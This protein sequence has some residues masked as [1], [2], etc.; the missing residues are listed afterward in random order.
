MEVPTAA[1]AKV[2]MLAAVGLAT[3]AAVSLTTTPTSR[4]P[5][6]ASRPLSASWIATD[7]YPDPSFVSFTA[8]SYVNMLNDPGRTGVFEAA[9]KQRLKGREGEMVVLDIGTGP[10]ALLALF[11]ARAGAKKVYAV[12]VQPAV[13]E[14]AR[15]AVRA[16][17]DVPDGCIE[18]FEGF[19][20]ELE[21]PEP[22]DLLVSEIVGNIAS[23]EGIYATMWDAQQRLVRHPHDPATYIPLVVETLAAPMSY[24]QHHPAL[25][26]EDFDWDA[27]REYAPPPRLSTEATAVTALSAPQRLETIRFDEPLPPPGTVLESVLNFDVCAERMAASTKA[28]EALLLASREA[29][30]GLDDDSACDDAAMLNVV[31]VSA[32]VGSSVSGI[33]LWPR[34][35]MDDDASLVVE[36]RAADGSPRKSCWEMVVPLLCGTP[37]RVAA[38]DTFQ[39]NATVT[40]GKAI[41]DPV[42]YSLQ[43]RVC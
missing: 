37:E 34:L 33:G 42:Q 30:D 5:S 8:D 32:E 10:E 35:V 41:D 12:E 21:L 19:S 3:A 2:F 1:V 24:V 6:V 40:I 9:I 17:T 15:Q 25:S 27:V 43:A 36:T 22:A 28:C 18:I 23:A 11:A 26:P 29:E 39:V 4:A 31:E 20:T 13:A 14:A 16:A 38:G 7:G